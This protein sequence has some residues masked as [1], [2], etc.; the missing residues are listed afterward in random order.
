[1]PK[2]LKRLKRER[3]LKTASLSLKKNIKITGIKTAKK[4]DPH[5]PP[6]GEKREKTK[7]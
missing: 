3:S 4:R 7:A 6:P 2:S 5:K 1:M